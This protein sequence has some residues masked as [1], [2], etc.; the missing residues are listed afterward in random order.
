M[1]AE[2]RL[3]QYKPTVIFGGLPLVRLPLASCSPRQLL[4]ASPLGAPPPPLVAPP[5]LVITQD[6]VDRPPQPAKGYEAAVAS[7]ITRR[8]GEINT[9]NVHANVGRAAARQSPSLVTSNMALNLNV[10]D[11]DEICAWI[12]RSSHMARL[13][14]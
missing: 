8:R 9:S 10:S 13:G 6:E 4:V 7:V 3:T 14:G 12:W 1:R 11:D 2:G 5:S